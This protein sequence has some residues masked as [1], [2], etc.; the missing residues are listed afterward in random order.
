MKYIDMENWKRKDHYNF[1]KELDYPH[2]NICG[3]LDITN[4]YKHIKENELPFFISVLYAAT[5]TANNIKEFRYRI[6]EDKVI[7]HEVVSP[8]FTVMTEGDVF[9]FC[10]TNFMED[11]TEFKNN[12]L[13]EIEKVKNKALIEDEPGR[14]DLLYVTSIPWISFTSITH[15]VHIKAVDS[16]PRI[17]WGKYFDEAGRIKL[18]FSVQAHHALVD[19]IHVGQFFNDLQEIFDN[20][21][22]YL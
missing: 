6:R 5:K 17:A 22:R 12:A 13:K 7:E 10:P 1:F 9:S 8:N 21:E 11:F 2:F 14:D 3:N 20:P 4:F 15:P 16:I 18:P 19:G